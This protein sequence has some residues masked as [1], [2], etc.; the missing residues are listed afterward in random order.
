VVHENLG[1]GEERVMA[2]AFTLAAALAAL[3]SLGFV[4]PQAAPAPQ[5]PAEPEARPSFKLGVVNLRTCFEKDKYERMKEVQEEFKKRVDDH[6]K[7]VETLGKEM[8]VLRDK[9]AGFENPSSP[10]YGKIEM[11]LAL[12]QAELEYLKKS[13]RA[14]FLDHYNK[15]KM[16]IYN[17]IRRVVDILGKEQK[18]DLI[19]RMEEPELEKEDLPTLTQQIASR[20]VLYHHEG[21]DLTPLVV[22]RLNQEWRKGKAAAEW[23]CKDCK[24]KNNGEKCSKCQKNKP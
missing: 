16:E 18:Y 3:G 8:G 2:K 11:E 20:V 5:K 14:R 21:V 7:Q 23:E 22:E 19:L 9:L 15:V 12:K 10:L 1:L 4:L 17:E 24:V 6:N 13:G